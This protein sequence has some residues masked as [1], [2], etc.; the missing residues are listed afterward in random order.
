MFGALG[1]YVASEVSGVV[2]RNVTVLILY[3]FAA[4]LM[5]C[6]AGYGLSALHSHLSFSLGVVAASLWLAGGLFVL[7]LVMVGLAAYVKN[8][9]RP[10]RPLPMAQTAMLAAPF[11]ARFAKSKK[12]SWRAAAVG[13]VVV[14][15][16]VLG[17]RLFKGDEDV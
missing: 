3:G 9:P 10:S 17:R 6:A 5:V 12:M 2:K 16:L 8:K 7:A 14:L 4:L 13:G 15:G 11:A 1:A